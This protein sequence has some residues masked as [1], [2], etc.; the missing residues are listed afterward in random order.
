[1]E[2]LGARVLL[3]VLVRRV[4]RRN[5]CNRCNGGKWW[6]RIKRW[7]GIYWWNRIDRWHWCCRRN[8]IDGRNR[9][10]RWHW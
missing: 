1:M 10:I 2:K 6:N 9:I 7:N 8:G 4:Y 5:G 3:E